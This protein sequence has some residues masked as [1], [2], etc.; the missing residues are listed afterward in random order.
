[1]FIIHQAWNQVGRKKPPVSRYNFAKQS[2]EQ[3]A[4][5]AGGGVHALLSLLQ[6]AISFIHGVPGMRAPLSC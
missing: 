3:F 2:K 4:L 1:M 5:W 6:C